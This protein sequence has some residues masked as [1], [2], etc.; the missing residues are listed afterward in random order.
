MLF[1]KTSPVPLMNSE[2]TV[3][4]AQTESH[5]SETSEP[6]ERCCWLLVLRHPPRQVI[7]NA[8]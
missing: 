7:L 2:T 5:T 1:C 6:L 3:P 8:S 4:P